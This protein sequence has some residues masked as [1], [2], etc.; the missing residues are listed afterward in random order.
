[1]DE[2]L[3]LWEANCVIGGIYFCIFVMM[4]QLDQGGGFHCCDWVHVFV[5]VSVICVCGRLVFLK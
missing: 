5:D 1:V 3:D 2:G 4:Q